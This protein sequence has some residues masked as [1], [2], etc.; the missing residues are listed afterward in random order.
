ML[1]DLL[2][3]VRT[4]AHRAMGPAVVGVV[5]ASFAACGSSASSTHSSP[6][7]A[8]PASV[9][10]P[11]LPTVL[12]LTQ[13]LGFHHMSIPA[14][15]ATVR[16]IAARSQRYRV[17]FL[18]S[19]AQLTPVALRHAVAVMFLLTTGELPMKAADKRA[20]VAFVRGGGGLIG[21]HSATDTFHHWGAFKEMIGAEFSHHPHPSTQR[22]TVTDH[23]TP[24]THSLPASFRIDEEFYVFKHDPRPHVHVLAELDTG[25]GG[26]DRP[27]VWCRGFG[28]GRVYY[29]ALGHFSA[30]WHTQYQLTLMSGGIQWAAGLADTTGCST[31]SARARPAPRLSRCSAGWAA[32]GAARRWEPVTCS[33]RGG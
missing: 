13:T 5:A 18:T 14:A 9:A 10:K 15:M 2:R 28:R 3:P 27:L 22:V 8:R 1:Y 11:A 16:A 17:V 33:R 26:P 25:S 24:A 4:A 29:D 12:V 19:A 23:S 32:A 6:L 7:A 30:T 20:L 31:P 21:V